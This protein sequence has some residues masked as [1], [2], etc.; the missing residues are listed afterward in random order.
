MSSRRSVLMDRSLI[1][2]PY[3]A[4]VFAIE[5]LPKLILEK[6]LSVDPQIDL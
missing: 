1:Y 3:Y 2:D 6:L 5:I 4:F